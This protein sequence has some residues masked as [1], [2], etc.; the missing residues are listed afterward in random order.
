MCS[1]LGVDFGSFVVSIRRIA[2]LRL[3][4][5]IGDVDRRSREDEGVVYG[6]SGKVCRVK[7]KGGWAGSLE[8]HRHEM[9]GG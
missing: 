5:W 7:V 9:R 3:I 4:D 1:Y 8:P 6:K 2:G